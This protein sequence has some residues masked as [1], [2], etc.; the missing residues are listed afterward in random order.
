MY[1]VCIV[2]GS[3]DRPLALSGRVAGR[4]GGDLAGRGDG[5]NAM[6]SSGPGR[7]HDCAVAVRRTGLSRHDAHGCQPPPVRPAPQNRWQPG[8]GPIRQR[9][10][11]VREHRRGHRICLP[12]GRIVS[13][14]QAAVS[15]PGRL[16]GA[17]QPGLPQLDGRV[18]VQGRGAA[19]NARRGLRGCRLGDR[20]GGG[21]AEFALPG[22]RQRP[23][24]AAQCG[25]ERRRH[26]RKGQSNR[27]RHRG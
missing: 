10:A 14:S 22:G 3:R 13:R 16:A 15:R 1:A 9:G 19:S 23:V 12:D 17:V 4:M 11:T 5:A 8:A 6:Q 2:V 25:N 7:P 21:R 24:R 18:L 27:R 26:A 20:A